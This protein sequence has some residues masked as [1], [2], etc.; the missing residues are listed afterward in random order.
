[1][2]NIPRVGSTLNHGVCNMKKVV[3]APTVRKQDVVKCCH[4]LSIVAWGVVTNVVTPYIGSYFIIKDV[5]IYNIA[6]PS[7][8]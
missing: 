6:R 7:A 1:M 2:P 8:A 3:I 4:L 5:I